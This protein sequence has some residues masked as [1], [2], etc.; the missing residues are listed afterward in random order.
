MSD[1]TVTPVSGSSYFGA[2][3][4]KAKGQLDMSTF[5]NLL[6]TQLQNQNPLEPMDD[7]A[8]YGQMAQLGQVQGMQ[9]LNASADLQQAQAIL[10]KTITATRPTSSASGKQGEPFTG[11]VSSIAFK[12]GTQYLN[13]QEDGDGGTVQIQLASIQSVVPTVDVAGASNLIGKYVG[14]TVTADGAATPVYGKVIGISAEDGVA[15][16]QVQDAKGK[17]TAVPVSSLTQIQTA[18]S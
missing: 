6:V 1:T 5:L 17:T 4:A 15:V 13:V 7:A 2:T 3:A 8:F 18:S 14:G 12:N 16:A 9:K 10:G 11:V